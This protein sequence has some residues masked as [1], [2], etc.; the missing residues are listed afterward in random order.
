MKLQVDYDK[1][2]LDFD[3]AAQLQ[4][5]TFAKMTSSHKMS[6]ADVELEDAND[7]EALTTL[8][9]KIFRY[10][11]D[12][13]VAAK[14][15][16]NVER[17]V[18][19]ALESVF[20]RIGLKAF[21][22]LSP[23]DKDLQMTELGRIVLGIRLFNREQKRGGTGLAALDTTSVKEAEDFLSEIN[24]EVEAFADA[25]TRYQAAIIE[26]HRLERLRAYEESKTGE[27]STTQ[28]SRIST[29]VVQRWSEELAN[30]RQYLGFLRSLQEEVRVLHANI[31]AAVDHIKST[32]TTI[33]SL[34]TNKTAVAKEVI[35]PRFDEVGGKWHSLWERTL[36]LQARKKTYD[37]ITKFRL[38]FTPTLSE[39]K[40][41]EVNETAVSTSLAEVI[42]SAR[43]DGTADSAVPSAMMEREAQQDQRASEGQAISSTA[44]LLASQDTPDFMLLP[45]ELQGY[46]PWTIIHGQ[47]L[48]I[49]GKPA[50]GVI[51]YNNMY[52]VCDHELAVLD[53]MARPEFYLE[54]VRQKAM[55]SPEYI[56]LLRIQNWFPKQS[57][58]R[59]LDK[60]EFDPGTGAR[61]STTADAST[62]TPTH[63][64]ERRIDINYHW[65]EWELRR[66]ALKVVNL[67]QCNTTAQQTDK[68]HFKRDNTSQVYL[69]RTKASQTRK[70][71]GTN[72][73]IK[74]AYLAGYRGKLPEIGQSISR[75]TANK[76]ATDEKPKPRIVILTTDF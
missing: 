63:F 24:S 52:F 69:P 68:S 33:K 76:K 2:F 18:A 46:C 53:V 7:F 13:A 62:E 14:V 70:D 23:D 37:S 4:L 59:L 44:E 41:M 25:C 17:E 8:Y 34:V 22:A 60:S 73:P 9:R 61:R 40:Y 47:G 55:E 54:S 3:E 64:V 30:R 67:R 71:A 49:P 11:L 32:L 12:F 27:P 75:Y 26:A 48:I 38:S 15:D 20:P 50:L 28:D 42:G 43:T 5:R 56:H 51:R 74:T 21:V 31:S 66:R 39:S 65:N 16:K 29:K 10:L 45:L 6:V 19:A 58:A 57:I 72:P 36:F 35:Y 1:S